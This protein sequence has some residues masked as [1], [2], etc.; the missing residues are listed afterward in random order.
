LGLFAKGARF[1]AEGLNIAEEVNHPASLMIALFGMG[2]LSLRQGDWRRALPLLE[3]SMSVCRDADLSSY[4][5]LM[6]TGLGGAYTMVGRAADAVSLL[7]QALDPHMSGSNLRCLTA[8]SEA[9]LAA[10]HRAEAYTSA[11]QALAFAQTSQSRGLPAY[12]L[13][14]LGDIAMH[15]DSP[16]LEQ[17]AT[18]YQQALALAETLG[19]RPLQA[20]CLRTLGNL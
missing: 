19:M 10:A 11:E 1:G 16:P 2:Q 17:A 9:Y 4:F 13:R 20:H 12:A 5:S 14:L 7:T 6:A 18:H 15:S 8:L 3:Q